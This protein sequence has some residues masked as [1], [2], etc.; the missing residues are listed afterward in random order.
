M[1]LVPAF[2]P[3][4]SPSSVRVQ[5]FSRTHSEK[6]IPFH[7]EYNPHEAFGPVERP[8]IFGDPSFFLLVGIRP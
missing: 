7:V 6:D 2:L 3:F 8:G 1:T 5:R 4:L